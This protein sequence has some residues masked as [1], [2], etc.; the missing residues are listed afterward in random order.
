MARFNKLSKTEKQR[1]LIALCQAVSSV[2]NPQEAA[3]VLTDL[4]TPSEIEMVAKRLEIA[5]LLIQGKT[6]DQIRIK[7]NAGYSTIGRV[8]TWLNLAGEG[9]KIAVSRMKKDE[10]LPTINDK[11]D[12]FSWYNIGR[13]Y[14]TRIWPFLAIEE[15]IKTAKRHEKS[16]LLTIL[17]SMEGKRMIFTKE[18]NRAYFESFNEVVEKANKETMRIR[19]HP[20]SKKT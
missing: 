14:P 10:K 7:I 8:N 5:K 19:A 9:F 17:Q 18:T 1:L 4:L 11:I 12:P 15:F 2:N 20:K 6:Y 13:R 3:Q 16:K